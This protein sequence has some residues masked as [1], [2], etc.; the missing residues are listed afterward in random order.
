MKDLLTLDRERILGIAAKYGASNVRVF[1]S[2]ARGQARPDSD[3][4]LLVDLPDTASLLDTVNLTQELERELGRK[5]DVLTERGLYWM[6]KPQI[7][8][9]ARP[10]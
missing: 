7:L 4:D 5:V 10:L 8:A 6:L 3:L 9:E 1:G 2:Y